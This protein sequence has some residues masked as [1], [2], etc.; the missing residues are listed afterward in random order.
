M[1]VGQYIERIKPHINFDFSKEV[2]E[3]LFPLDSFVKQALEDALIYIGG[4]V[5]VCEKY[6]HIPMEDNI[7]QYRVS[8]GMLTK[9]K[10][11]IAKI[12]S[13]V[14]MNKDGATA[15][16]DHKYVEEIHPNDPNL[17]IKYAIIQANNELQLRTSVTISSVAPRGSYDSIE[18]IP[19][20]FVVNLT[21][22]ALA[23]ATKYIINLESAS[24]G[25]YDYRQILSVDGSY[26]CTLNDN[27]TSSSTNGNLPFDWSVNDKIY[28]CSGLPWMV[29]ILF[30][31]T[32]M[33]GYFSTE[34]TIPIANPYLPYLDAIVISN[35]YNILS[36]RN[37]AFAQVYMSRVQSGILPS[38]LV[39]MTEIKK[40]SNATIDPMV[41]KLY[42]PFPDNAQY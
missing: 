42:N 15:E 17:A 24:N 32:V 40:L 6:I 23:V 37:P 35:L 25:I 10:F 1:T 9:A 34:N 27:V 28:V 38:K 8:I 21:T 29:N 3:T 31:G 22:N 39:A 7:R 18:T 14:L 26:N 5:R 19:S 12:K 20:A 36:S 4:T 41:A 30:Q 11:D 33:P 13:I 16:V 2:Q